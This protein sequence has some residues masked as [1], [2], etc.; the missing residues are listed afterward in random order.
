MYFGI[1]STTAISLLSLDTWPCCILLLYN[2]LD[3]HSSVVLPNHAGTPL[4]TLMILLPTSNLDLD[5]LFPCRNLNVAL[6]RVFR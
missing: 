5:S 1:N 4:G 3:R 2:Q 6:G